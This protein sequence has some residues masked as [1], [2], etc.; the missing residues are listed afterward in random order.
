VSFRLRSLFGALATE[1]A[2]AIGLAGCALFDSSAS[3]EST[4][5]GDAASDAASDGQVEAG[6]DAGADADGGGDADAGADGPAP[7]GGVSDAAPEAGQAIDSA[8]IQ[9]GTSCSYDAGS[10]PVGAAVCGDGWKASTEQ[11]DDGLGT[12][13]TRRGCSSTCKVLDELAVAQTGDGGPANSPHALGAGRHSA[14]AGTSTFA[15][16]HVETTSQPL[17]LSLATFTSKAVPTGDVR[18]FN[19]RSTALPESNPVIAALPCDSYVAAWTDFGGDGDGLGV[20]MTVVQPGVTPSAPPVFANATAVF[21]Q[22]DPDVVAVGS[23]IVVAWVDDSNAATQPDIRIRTFDGPTLA[24]LTPEQTLA[25]TADSE[26]D[27]A[28]APFA[29]SWAAAWRDD[30]NGLET[31]R[32][33]TGSTDWNVG[34][35]FLPAPTTS[36]PALVQLDAT[37]LLLAYAVGVPPA[38]SAGAD[39]AASEAGKP[40]AGPAAGSKIQVAVLDVAMP[41]DVSGVDIVATVASAFGLSQSQ[42]NVVNVNTNVFVAWRTDAMPGDPNGEELWL[43]PLSW[44]GAALSTSAAESPL[45]RAAA[46]RAGDQRNVGLTATTLPPGGA[47]LSAWDDLG[48]G[49]ASGEGNGDMVVQLLPVNGPSGPPSCQAGGNGLTNC[50][51]SSESCCVSAAVPGGSYFRS[52]DGVT[53][54]YTSQSS[55]A[56][57][58]S[59]RL[60]KYETTIGRFRQFVNAVVGGWL[61][62][63]GSGK[64]THLNGGSGLANSGSPGTFET[65]WDSSWNTGIATTAAGWN[66]SLQC[67]MSAWTPSPGSNEN[68]PIGCETWFEAYA[69]CIWDGGFLPSEA[70]WNY[71]AAGGSEQRVYP[72]S[73]PPTASTIDCTYANIDNTNVGCPSL[74]VNN[75]VGTDSPKGDG[76]WGHADLGGNVAEWGLDWTAA[77]YDTPCVDCAHLTASATAPGTFKTVRGGGSDFFPAA[78]IA[79]VRNQ[80]NVPTL[81]GY[82]YGIRCARTP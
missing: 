41:G 45:P 1:L 47:L 15:V 53:P 65:G 9:A 21:S 11:C 24:P 77:P 19:V 20:A 67:Q 56:T 61:P 3:L 28:L 10:A 80:N 78:A 26:A 37:H 81:R 71:A 46:D 35:A 58:S 2:V 13:P 50:G 25:A 59:F 34:P 17:A 27:V 68:R 74:F 62:P 12:A 33:H 22:F 75:N 40:D 29:G 18:R 82:D 72:W 70:E 36:K 30:F 54:G 76:K 44:N 6:R 69:F 63:A 73:V 55:P 7:E 31:I 66:T 5:T 38:A 16:A 60:D 14:A 43:K 23:Q 4:L 52:Y 42:P 49:L 39:A 48:K 79:S 32:V 8:S 64:H 51:P 57:V